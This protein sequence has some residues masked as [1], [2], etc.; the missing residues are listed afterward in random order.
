MSATV[1]R[2]ARAEP[3][4]HPDARRRA[5]SRRAAFLIEAA[6]PAGLLILAALLPP[7]RPLPFDLCLWHRLTGHP[8]LGCGLTRSVCHL[9]H[10]DVAGSLSLHPLGVVITALVATLAVRGAGR[11]LRRRG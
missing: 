5:G 7:D 8:C 3:P 10:G 6:A 9:M 2:V 1:V 4:V 11:F